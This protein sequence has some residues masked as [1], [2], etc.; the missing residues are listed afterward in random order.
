M[1]G[2][3][4]L[5]QGIWRRLIRRVGQ[6]EKVIPRIGTAHVQRDGELNMS[7]KCSRSSK[8]SL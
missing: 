2:G 5:A 8:C 7:G 4:I 6:G 1:E 3:S